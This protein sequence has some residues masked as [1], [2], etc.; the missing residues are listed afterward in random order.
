MEKGFDTSSNTSFYEWMKVGSRR[1]AQAVVPF[2]VELL[3]PRSVVD[4]GCGTGSWLKV[5]RENGVDELLGLESGSIDASLLEIAPEE[6]LLASVLDELPLSRRF[7]LALCL[8]VAHYLPPETAPRLVENLSA[9]APAVLFSS[10]IPGQGGADADEPSNQQWPDYWAALFEPHGYVCV[11]CVRPRIWD[12]EE[13]EVWYA[14]NTVLFAERSLL[15]QRPALASE[16]ERARGRP[17]SV[18]HP[19]MFRASQRRLS[20]ALAELNRAP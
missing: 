6:L 1:S 16:Y 20:R 14:Q 18:V 3:E 9:L 17:L 10:A 12:D 13:V 19:R 8:E 5:F 2:L 15:E 7:D 11:D 4:A